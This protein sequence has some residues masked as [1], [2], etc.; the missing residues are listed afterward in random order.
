M[1]T[2]ADDSNLPIVGRNSP[3][4]LHS[5]YDLVLIKTRLMFWE[6]EPHFVPVFKNF[7]NVQRYT[8][9]YSHNEGPACLQS[10][11][12]R[13]ISPQVYYIIIIIIHLYIYFVIK[14]MW[15][16]KLYWIMTILQ[17]NSWKIWI[18]KSLLLILLFPSLLNKKCARP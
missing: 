6:S 12:C 8:S 9:C 16:K 13:Y 15:K 18:I 11:Y 3:V 4:T 5:L 2:G 17:I 14:N 10:S 1:F 7:C